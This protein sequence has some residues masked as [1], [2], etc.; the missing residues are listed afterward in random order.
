MMMRLCIPFILALCLLGCSSP[1]PD[2]T[3]P[4]KFDIREKS[5]ENRAP[6][7]VLKDLKGAD[8]RLSDYKNRPVLLV[9]STTWCRY[10]RDEIPHIKKLHASYGRKNLEIINIFV[11]ET[12]GKVAAFAEKHELPYRVV[13]DADGQ[14]ADRY[15]VKGVPTIVFIDREGRIVCHACRSI[16]T[17]LMDVFPG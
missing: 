1:P 17:V 10:C 4:K 13:L 8:V 7:F 11:Q 5:I 9:F 3:K 16:D 2:S 12:A 14:V 6:D 15:D